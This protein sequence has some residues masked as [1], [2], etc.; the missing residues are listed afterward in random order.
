MSGHMVLVRQYLKMLHQYVPLRL[1]CLS[2][3][4]LLTLSV[5]KTKT[6]S[7]QFLS[8]APELWNALSQTIRNIE[9]VSKLIDSY[10]R[11]AAPFSSPTA[12]P[13]NTLSLSRSQ[14]LS[15]LKIHLFSL[16]TSLKFTTLLTHLRL[17]TGQLREY[18]NT[19]GFT[20]A[21]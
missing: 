17:S 8:A 3:N 20:G 10:C 4:G 1:L 5:F 9:T 13:F 11:M 19:I 12:L 18:T 16:H 21:I 2:D 15:R 14:F 7:R 6:A